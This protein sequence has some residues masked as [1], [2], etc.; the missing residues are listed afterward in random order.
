MLIVVFLEHVDSIPGFNGSYLVKIDWTSVAEAC[1]FNIRGGVA[2][3]SSAGSNSE[4]FKVLTRAI[5]AGLPTTTTAGP[6]SLPTTAS[7]PTTTPTAAP[8]AP[9]ITSIPVAAKIA[10]ED[11][12]LSAGTKAAIGV[13]IPL[14]VIAVLAGVFL[15]LR[16]RKAGAAKHSTDLAQ[17]GQSYVEYKAVYGEKPNLVDQVPQELQGNVGSDLLN[18]GT[19]AEMDSSQ[20]PALGHDNKLGRH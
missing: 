4:H 7:N 2:V 9:S 18:S 10:K 14:A 20:T 16:R 13:T 11:G 1:W 6:T 19:P 17:G 15:Y 5:T 12:G 3:D 8:A